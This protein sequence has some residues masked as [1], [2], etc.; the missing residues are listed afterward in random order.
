[1]KKVLCLL[2][3]ASLAI[4]GYPKKHI[5][6][7]DIKDQ[8]PI[9]GASVI[10]ANGLIIG[11]TDKDG[12]IAITKADYPLCLRSLGYEPTQIYESD[13]DSI[14]L[15]PASYTLPEVV[16]TPADRPI[17][18]VVTYARE[19]CTGATP[20]DTLQLY[21]DYMLEYFFANGK[22]K[23]YSKLDQS[24]NI[25]ANR[26]F[27]RIANISGLDSIMRPKYDDDIAMLSFLPNMAFVPFEQQ[28]LTEAMKA[29]AKS[30]TIQGKFFPKYIYRINNGYFTI[31]CDVLSDYKN[32]TFSPWFFKVL[33]MTMDMQDGS[34]SLIYKQNESGKYG[35]SDF[36]Y[37]IFNMH[38]LGK[39]KQLK[40]MIGVKDAIHIN[41][42]LEQYPVEIE[43]MT[44]QE[45]KEMKK[46]Y[47]ERHE[48]FRLPVNIQPLAPTIQTLVERID[49]EIPQNKKKRYNN[50]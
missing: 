34:W 21:C 18:R 19:Y 8:A 26:R 17:T 14:F 39:G 31:D 36:V 37:G 16:I 23:G 25:L 11:I 6:L 22:V 46:T 33:G 27:G 10:S 13:A 1:M 12:K 50:E 47:Y 5:T 40:R 2:L 41:C 48:D 30:D 28:G 35:I 9:A 45:Y 43:R 32:H 3:A 24:P 29:G 4:S 42:Y 38:F 15:N 44:M 20:A 7:A 49:R